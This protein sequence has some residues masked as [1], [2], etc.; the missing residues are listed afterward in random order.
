MPTMSPDEWK[1][2]SPY[3]DNAL[4][5]TDEEC[6]IWLSS[7]R[8]QSPDLVQQLEMLLTEHRALSEEEFLEERCV[9]LP[10]VQ[11]LAGQ[12]VGVYTLVSQIG[13]GGMGSV[14]L[15][16]RNDGRFE[17]QVA[18]KFLNVALMGKGGEERFKREGS[19]LGRLA[20]PHIAELIDAGVSQTG[21]PY[22]VLEHIEGH[23]I[24]RY[25]DQR[26]LNVEARI[27]L[28]LNVLGAVAKAHSNLIVHR[29]LKPA[30]VLVRNNGQVKLLDFGI[31]K[32]LEGDG[33]A[34]GAGP[35]TAEGARAMTP[36]YA[37]PE[38]LLGGTITTATDVYALGV[39]LF[40]LLTGQHPAGEG[41]HTPANLVKAIVDTEPVRPSDTVAPIR[42]N[43]K[44]VAA[45]AARR[46]TTPDKL[47]RLLRGD[48]DTIVAK[49]MKKEPGERYSSVTALA[50]DLRR[51]LR[52]E[53]ITA[54]PDTLSYRAI[55]F[56]RRNRTAVVLATL[57]LATTAAGLVGT[58]MQAR[59]ARVQ[60]DFALRQLVR[61]QATIEFNEFLLSDAA[62]S[63][64]PFTVNE[65]LGRAEDVLARQQAA[66]DTSR[67]ELM[68][69]IGD[70]Y[71]TQDED[72]KARR[73]L[74]QAYILSRRGHE[75]IARAESACSLAGA[76]ARDGELTR[77]EALIQEGLGELP[78]G[79]QYDLDRIFCLRRG[80][81]VAQERGDPQQGITRME[82]VK[83]IL[84]HSPFD[85][86][87]L[88]LHASI[89]L[90]EAYRVAG[91]NE[92]A[93]S[94]F[95]QAAA[96]L[97]PLGR[98]DTQTAVVIF[99]D[100]ALALDKLGQ[101]MEAERLFRRAI[102]ISRAGQTEE[103]VSPILLNNY[104]KTLYQLGRLEESADYA[105]RAYNKALQTRDQ[106]A[107][108]QSLYVRALIDIEQHDFNHA[109]AMLGKVEPVIRRS[110]PSDSFW[111]GLLASAQALLASGRGDFQT[112]LPL[113]D[114]AVTI[115]EA[116]K[117]NGRSG[118][119]FLPIVLVRRSTVELEAGQ[120]ARA[121][122]D[123]ERALTQL[124]AASAPGAFS[125]HI[126]RAYL[127]Q[128]R[129]LQSQG[130]F[131]Q[132]N[133]AFRSAVENLQ[134]TVPNHPDTR[135]AQRFIQLDPQ[136]R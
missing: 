34:G 131:D 76:L 40:A 130:K 86:D 93:S 58:L 106:M 17:R 115:V 132:A 61:A 4:G 27:R 94:T 116:A 53:P 49:A 47:R 100:W 90:A 66:D 78:A 12:T 35:L 74:E 37:A 15:A 105:G 56:V 125:S 9:A 1:A 99:N 96:L 87:I 57:A 5:M 80:S 88:D 83:E 13:Q 16:E 26:K 38:Q 64:K 75:T 98:S 24:D 124:K 104:A 69:V 62:P 28:F 82:V 55:K 23:H 67:V 120:P 25:C 45:I 32:L 111:F 114:Q 33:E 3:L 95:E 65:L 77:A 19:I 113:A 128:G 129:A 22:L 51:Y 97:T 36:E 123:A 121:A 91:Q 79:S 133:A 117:K 48:L 44:I 8:V 135:S 101:P 118:S 14:W 71:S 103:T 126:G 110:L 31:A 109:A 119:D 29:D 70:Q 21:Q 72:A 42:T 68:V 52:N 7:L 112:A 46:D 136:P 20:H 2:L 18:V 50:D 107:I 54:R 122:D 73:V 30:N 127:N 60:R 6:S 41:P 102:E 92:L 89:E 85:S 84:R 63:G 43:A 108:Y 10:K 11:G 59:T 81:E 39:L 134:N